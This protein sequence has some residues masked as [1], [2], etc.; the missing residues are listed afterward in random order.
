MKLKDFFQEFNIR[1]Q[2]RKYGLPLWQCP[3][4]LFLLMGLVI[5]FTNAVVYAIGTRFFAEPQTVALIVIVVTI[6][7]FIMAFTIMRS[8]ERL[9]EVSRMK[10]EFVNV[11]SHQL[12]APISNL[13]WAIE[14]LMSGRIDQDKEKQAEYF[15]LLK[16]NSA[17]M[18]ELVSD[19]LTVSRI[20]TA[21]LILKKDK[22]FLA[23]VVKEVIN[24]FKI[25]AQSSHVEIK[26]N[27]EEGLPAILADR[28]QLKIAVE[29]LIE[30]AIRYTKGKGVVEVVLK[31]ADNAIF[32]AVKDD[33]EGIPKPDQKFIFHKFFRAQNARQLQTQGSG[34]GLYITKA[35]IEKS[36]GRIGFESQEGKGSRFWFNLPI[37]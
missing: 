16:E 7:L 9:A 6:V 4:F 37:K 26:T 29:N 17:R 3:Q 21:T 27:I 30:N 23:E 32:F 13:T 11:V 31:R 5:I 8:F 18:Q 20:E 1:G 19:L 25:F 28:S 24:A 34:L 15:E 10:T 22:V 2:C 36:G 35:I 14:F 12:R 33:G